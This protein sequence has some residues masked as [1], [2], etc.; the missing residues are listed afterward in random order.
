MKQHQYRITVEH[1]AD[2]KGQAV[3]AQSIQ[4]N[5]PNHD[6]LFAILQKVKTT[7]PEYDDET[8]Q[9][10]FVGLKMMGEVLLERRDDEFFA[11]FSPH[12]LNI[13]KIVKGKA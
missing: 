2:A 11:Q 3:E 9:R 6:D 4:F 5:A 13:M 1:L 10:F 7:H 8:L 12:F